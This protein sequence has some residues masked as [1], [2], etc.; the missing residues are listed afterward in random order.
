MSRVAFKMKLYPD[1]VDE[2]KRRHLE[3]WPGLVELLKHA[4]ISDYSIFIDEESSCLFAVLKAD[5][6]SSLD[7]L[8]HNPLMQQWWQYMSDIMETHSDNSPLSTPLK[9]VFYL[10]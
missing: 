8:P 4:G 3:I 5:D 7:Q 9:E 1:S 10:P 2:Y 6:E